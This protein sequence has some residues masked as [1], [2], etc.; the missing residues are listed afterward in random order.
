MD[1]SYYSRIESGA[2]SPT[3]D[4]LYDIAAALRVHVAE[5]FRDPS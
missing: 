2:Q 5:L 1:R 4:K 3:V